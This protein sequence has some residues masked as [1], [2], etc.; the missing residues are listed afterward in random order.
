MLDAS[1]HDLDAHR[2]GLKAAR[3][4]RLDL[5]SRTTGRLMSRM[6]AAAGVANAKVL[7]HPMTSRAV[8]HSSNHV[9]TSV[10]DFHGRLGIERGRQ[11]VEARRW[12]E[13][14]VEVRDKVLETGA[15][16]VDVAKR[17]G[18]ET[19]DRAR[20]VTGKVAS[21]IAE[22]VLRRREDDGESRLDD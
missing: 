6:D 19:A 20:T 9:A 2:L 1:P 18:S 11:D 5:I 3:R 17:L 22:R 10:V 13:A 21:G 8:V 12:G 14:A 15:E 4:N 7:L 16:G